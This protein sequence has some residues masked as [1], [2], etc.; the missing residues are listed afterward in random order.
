MQQN[1]WEKVQS[2]Q[3]TVQCSMFRVHSL[4]LQGVRV[5]V[6]AYYQHFAQ[7]RGT[8]NLEPGTWNSELGTRNLE[9][10]TWNSELGTWNS[11]LRTNKR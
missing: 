3:F 2:L 1:R 6:P 9:L 10:A 5:P 8:R 11:E 7:A 4:E